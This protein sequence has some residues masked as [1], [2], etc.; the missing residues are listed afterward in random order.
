VFPALAI[1]YLVVALVAPLGLELVK[2]FHASPPWQGYVDALSSPVLRFIFVRTLG[3]A[4]VATAITAMLAFPVAYALTLMPSRLRALFLSVLLFPYITSLLV[5]TYAW[6]GL[7]GRNGPVAA[8]LAVLGHPDASLIDTWWA[9]LAVLVHVFLPFMILS[10]YVSMRS[11][12]LT[13]LR[14]AETLGAKP[15][16]AFWAVY[17]PQTLP[18]LIAGAVLTFAISAGAYAIP[19]LI[20][21]P[22]ESTIGVVVVVFVTTAYNV[23][24]ALPVA[25][26]VLLSILVIVLVAF[27]IRAAG[28]EAV[29][30]GRPG[31]GGGAL[32]RSRGRSRPGRRSLSRLAAHWPSL[33]R[34]FHLIIAAATI[35]ALLIE[36]SP[37]VYL[38]G[39]SLQPLP[40]LAFPTQSVSFRW[41]EAVFQDPV[42]LSAATNSIEIALMA[43]VIA[44]I[45]GGYLAVATFRGS[46]RIATSIMSIAILPLVLPYVMYAI[47]V[48]DVFVRINWVGNW[49]AIALAHSALAWPYAYVNILAGL[50]SYD[51]RLD[52]AASS[53]GAGPVRRLW[54]VTFP[55]L[56]PAIIAGALLAMLLSLD[57]LV[58]TLFL[59]GIGFK[60][61]PLVFFADAQEDISP[62]LA[63][64][65]VLLVGT[66]VAIAIVATVVLSRSRR[67]LAKA[68]VEF[69]F[70]N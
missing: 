24:Q 14:A 48:Y 3:L 7:L 63:V 39:A 41:Y 67:R 54:R 37:F 58:V 61:L 64:V 22:S 49:W 8:L 53:L 20:G 29:L 38:V 40:L 13:Q 62:A 33:P 16:E 70:E 65:G 68:E 45:V 10:T 18:G 55:I 27:G 56:R 44:V 42:W 21:G 9:I 2:S 59:A 34:N 15:L 32:G 50:S 36:D 4:A 43:T 60:T 46:A 25:L 30:A 31:G 6:M 17:A 57:E 23:S 51:V 26:A 47:G 52:A 69:A 19:A 5:R 12:D 35:G 1:V 11:I 66:T 28:V